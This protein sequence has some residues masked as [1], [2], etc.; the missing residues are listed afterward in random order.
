MSKK[1]VQISKDPCS[2]LYIEYTDE[3]NKRKKKRQLWVECVES[4]KKEQ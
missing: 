3:S 1:E 2:K 4:N